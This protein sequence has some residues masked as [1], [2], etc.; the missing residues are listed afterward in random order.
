MAKICHYIDINLPNIKFGTAAPKTVASI[1]NVT[2]LLALSPNA[3]SATAAYGNLK[4][5]L[6]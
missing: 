5:N 1:K 4:Y 6:W 2:N 3:N